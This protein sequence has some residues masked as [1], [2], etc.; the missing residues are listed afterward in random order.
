[1]CNNNKTNKNPFPPLPDLIFVGL[2]FPTMVEKEIF[3]SD[4]SKEITLKF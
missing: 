1:M 2:S 4:N 3:K